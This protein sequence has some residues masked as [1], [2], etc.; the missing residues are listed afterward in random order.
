MMNISSE[1]SVGERPSI[2]TN[3]RSAVAAQLPGLLRGIK[4]IVIKREEAQTA[5][6]ERG[7][8]DLDQFKKSRRCEVSV[9]V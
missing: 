2:D 4:E 9:R 3:H 7:S 8:C 5:A 1:L 6:E